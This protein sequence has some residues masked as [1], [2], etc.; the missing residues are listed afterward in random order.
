MKTIALIFTLLLVQVFCLAVN[1]DLQRTRE[2]YYKASA[3]KTDAELFSDFL[4]S[5][6]DVEKTLLSGY[7]GMSYM[8]RAN[9]SWNP[10]NKLS[11]FTKGKDLLDGAI[12][13]DPSNMEL[14][15]LRFCVQTN[16]PGFLGYSG[17]IVQDKAVIL[18][19]YSQS[20]DKD[21]KTRIKNYLVSSKYCTAS[22]KAQLNK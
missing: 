12:R 21:L 17:M 1:G 3:N 7:L 11:F 2:L 18:S 20:K 4:S 22:E 13:K 16:A 10:Y 9:Y 8:I 6:P 14:R 5:S 19:G 15:F